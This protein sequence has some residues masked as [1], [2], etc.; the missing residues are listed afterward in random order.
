MECVTPTAANLIA[1]PFYCEADGRRSLWSARVSDGRAAA[2]T[3]VAYIRAHEATP[4]L[5]HVARA[6]FMGGRFGAV[7][8]A[9]WQRMAERLL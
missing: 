7:E 5:G 8:I 9:F 1:L 2:D 6:Q 4:I 3:L